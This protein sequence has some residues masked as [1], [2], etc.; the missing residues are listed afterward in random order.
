[1]ARILQTP[2]RNWPDP[3]RIGIFELQVKNG[4]SEDLS[5]KFGELK[6]KSEDLNINLS[7]L[8]NGK[9]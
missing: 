8:W 1:M 5:M 2:S 3:I 7:Y 6:I 9:V 4:L